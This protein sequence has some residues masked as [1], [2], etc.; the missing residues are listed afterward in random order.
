MPSLQA[1][2]PDACWPGD[3]LVDGLV[4][5]LDGLEAAAFQLHD[6][7]LQTVEF[8]LT[9]LATGREHHGRTGLHQGDG[10]VQLLGQI[11]WRPHGTVQQLVIQTL[12]FIAIGK[13]L[14]RKQYGSATQCAC[15]E[16]TQARTRG[17]GHMTI[18]FRMTDTASLLP[19]QRQ[20]T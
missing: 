1:S 12:N 15:P 11:H 4:N 5:R 2:A 9:A 7:G 14:R 8:N 18:A 17:L 19:F 6:G 13:H 16:A 10:L 3:R 20:L